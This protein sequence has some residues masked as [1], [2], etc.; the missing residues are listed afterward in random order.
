VCRRYGLGNV[1]GTAIIHTPQIS[2]ASDLVLHDYAFIGRYCQ[3][4]PRVEIGRYTML[5]PCVSVVGGDH[6]YNQPGTPTIFA[7]RG[8]LRPTVIEDD[9]WIGCGSIIMA[10]VRIGRGSIVAAGS[11]VTKDVAPYEVHAGVPAH[12]ISNRFD[13]QQRIVHDE[14]L[15]A[16][17]HGGVY[18]GPRKV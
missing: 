7:G 17:A 4:C 12:K 5:A 2:L 1:H 14:M 13:D 6:D 3:I 15:R 11:V 16:P 10:G 18:C 8:N 9:V